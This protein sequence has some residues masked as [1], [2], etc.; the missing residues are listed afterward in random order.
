MI[1][2]TTARISRPLVDASAGQVGL[3]RPSH[4]VEPSAHSYAPQVGYVELAE[5]TLRSILLEFVEIDGQVVGPAQFSF[6]NDNQHD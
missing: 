4:P 5:R 1:L 2:M 6:S 3:I